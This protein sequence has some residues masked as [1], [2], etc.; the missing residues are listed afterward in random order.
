MGGDEMPELTGPDRDSGR[1]AAS[2][3]RSGRAAG[4]GTPR[5]VKVFGVVALVL[6]VLAVVLLLVGGHGPGRHT[7]GVAPPAGMA[8]GHPAPADGLG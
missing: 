2:D 7:G 8:H 3:E 6:V 5:W 4:G 1:A